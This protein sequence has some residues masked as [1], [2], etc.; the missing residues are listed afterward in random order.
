[1]TSRDL[2]KPLLDSLST[3]IILVDN[4]LL[5]RHLNPAAEALLSLSSERARGEPL[6]YFFTSRP[7]RRNSCS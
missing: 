3:A 5:L 6:T 4:N 1:V 2:H 7:R